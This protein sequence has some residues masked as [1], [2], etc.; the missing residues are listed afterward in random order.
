MGMKYNSWYTKIKKLVL[1]INVFGISK[2]VK[3]TIIYNLQ[4]HSELSIFNLFT[5]FQT[6][7]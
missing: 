7:V 6:I 4:I 3:L 5:K 2:K 1:V